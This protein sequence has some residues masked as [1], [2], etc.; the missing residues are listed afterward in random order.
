ML[1]LRDELA[2]RVFDLPDAWWPDQ[3]A[4]IGGRDRQAGGSWC[5]SDVG[6]GVTAV[7][8]NRPERPLAD[9]GAPSR[10]VLPL[11]AVQ[12]GERWSQHLEVDGMARFNLVLVTP[13]SLRWWAFDGGS[14]HEE[15]LP[16]GTYMFTP[17]GLLTSGFDGRLGQAQARL[18]RRP[19]RAD[20]PRRGPEWLDVVNDAVPDADPASLLVRRPSGDDSFETVFG[21]LIAAPAGNS[22][23]GLRDHPGQS[24]ALDHGTLAEVTVASRVR[25]TARHGLAG[26]VL[27]RHAR[28][29]SLDARLMTDQALR[30]DPFD[31]YDE[32]RLR[33]LTSRGPFGHVSASH[34]V[35]AALLR[36]ESFGVGLRPDALPTPVRWL[37]DASSRGAA[38]TPVEPPS[39][40]AVDPPTHTRYRRMVSRVFT[41]R[42]IEGLRGRIQVLATELL[43]D[44][45]EQGSD[46]V[47][48]VPTYAAQLP[49]TV[50]AEILGVPIEMQREFLEWGN[51]AAVTLDIGI[52][53]AEF[54]RAEKSLN[55]LRAWMLSHFARLRANPGDDLL[56]Q[57]VQ[58]QDEQGGLSEDELAATA[59]LLLGAGFETTVN[60]IG[61]G[62]TQL[63]AH[64]DQLA[65]LRENPDLWPNAVEEV[66]R[67]DSPV[68]RT[69][70]V[71]MGAD[72]AG[73]SL[74]REGATGGGHTWRRQP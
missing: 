74:A 7:V 39:M 30:A 28:R 36:S 73:R 45:A 14:L 31:A 29:G 18:P 8:L 38:P 52:T 51:G 64:P 2:S 15:L 24:P 10:G 69:A 49:V 67:F 68:Q 72:R 59:M 41:P 25:W 17:G 19:D 33:G 70:R 43:D 1:A 55:A 16:G 47:D 5:V 26:V 42:A 56:S 4:V 61:N 53:Y 46:A 44:L 21:Q 20:R 60:L 9:P 12:H 37:I 48:L 65:R 57:L 50:I 71:A 63:V 35:C 40:L 58:V 23:L 6:S 32:I 54:D 34:E 13:Q 66:L 22:A 11:L 27:R 3:P 62:T